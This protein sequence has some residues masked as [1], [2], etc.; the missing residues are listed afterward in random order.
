MRG[1]IHEKQ[2]RL[3]LRRLFS[4]DTIRYIQGKDIGNQLTNSLRGF[5]V[6]RE[7]REAGPPTFVEQ[8][9]VVKV[10]GVSVKEVRPKEVALKM[11]VVPKEVA[12]QLQLQGTVLQQ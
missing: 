11:E 6:Q 9:E 1:H 10:G 5:L 4:F 7:T 12:F 3:E 8:A 2:R